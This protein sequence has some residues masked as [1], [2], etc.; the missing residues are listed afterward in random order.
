MN[1][2]T[3]HTAVIETPAPALTPRDDTRK[4]VSEILKRVDNLIKNQQLEQA[5]HEVARAKEIDP[6]NVYVY[7]YEE[8]IA[9]LLEEL[10]RRRNDEL[11]RQEQERKRAEELQRQQE[12]ARKYAADEQRRREEEA[13]RAAEEERR[14]REQQRE[15]E[16]RRSAEEERRKRAME[17]QAPPVAAQ[18]ASAI[19]RADA[20]ATYKKFLAEVW[21][22]G[23]PDR[24]EE[25]RLLN[26]RAALSISLEEHAV[27]QAEVKHTAYATRVRRAWLAGLVTSETSPLL[28]EYQFQFRISPQEHAEIMKHVL[29]DIRA[30]QN[31]PSI[32]VIDDDVKMLDFLA[33]ILSVEGFDVHA[34]ATTDDAFK[35]LSSMKPDLILCDINLETSTM[36]GF[37]FYE[38]LQEVP[39]L[40]DVPFIFVSGLTDE[41]LIRAGKELGVDDY[42]T[43]PFSE[44]TL[45]ATIRGKLRRFRR[46]RRVRAAS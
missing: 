21:V 38:K 13:R 8:R 29:A 5:S 36:G 22:D 7:A 24:G 6:K 40:H 46:L 18:E 42:I 31:R 20:L 2:I 17:Q 14:R 37:S 35:A 1:K 43:K 44:E 32:M 39:E 16:Q 19:S 9:S 4:K 23:A 30:A 41:A 3:N 15:E 27:L 45:I 12:E 25:I 33:E 28:T 26:L 10:Q 11:K 34:Y